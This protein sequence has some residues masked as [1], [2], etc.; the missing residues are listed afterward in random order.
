MPKQYYKEEK[1]PVHI[2]LMGKPMQIPQVE[3]SQ[4]C[5]L[6]TPGTIDMTILGTGNWYNN[7]NP[8]K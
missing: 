7:L 2:F 8:K 6:L 5:A 4:G 3:Y 1:R